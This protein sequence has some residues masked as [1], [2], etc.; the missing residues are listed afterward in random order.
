MAEETAIFAGGCFWG[1]V[2]PLETVDGINRWYQ[3]IPVDMCLIQRMNKSAAIQLVIQK[4]LKFG[5]TQK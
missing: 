3:V 5:L 1:M 2:K 4:Q